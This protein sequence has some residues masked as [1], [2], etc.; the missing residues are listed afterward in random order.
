MRRLIS[1]L[2]CLLLLSPV[3]RV[4]QTY[5]H[6]CC[7][8]RNSG[9]QACCNPDSVQVKI[10]RQAPVP[11]PVIAS[12]RRTELPG[13]ASVDVSPASVS[14]HSLSLRCRILRI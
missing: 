10:E 7:H 2:A 13:R 12:L 9:A 3:L 8:T 14:V 11:V 6:A 4:Q 1:L 5:Q